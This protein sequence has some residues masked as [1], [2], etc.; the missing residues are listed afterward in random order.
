MVCG[1]SAPY[2]GLLLLS[3]L[4]PVPEMIHCKHLIPCPEET[5]IVG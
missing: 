4:V 5:E 2:T 1:G 3:G